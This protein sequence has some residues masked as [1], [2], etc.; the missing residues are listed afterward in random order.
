MASS[1]NNS[2]PLDSISHSL[3]LVNHLQAC[4]QA[5]AT[6]PPDLQASLSNFISGTTNTSQ[7]S[8]TSLSLNSQ[9]PTPPASQPSSGPNTPLRTSNPALPPSP[10]R[11]FIFNTTQEDAPTQIDT[12]VR[13]SQRSVCDKLYRFDNGTFLE[14]PETSKNGIAYLIRCDPDN[15]HSPQGD[16][17]YSIGPPGSMSKEGKPVTHQLVGDHEIPC[18]YKYRTC[19]G[20]KVCP[21]ADMDDVMD[22]HTKASREMVEERLARDYEHRQAGDFPTRAIFEKTVAFVQAIRRTGCSLEQH[23]DPVAHAPAKDQAFLEA[24][25]TELRRGYIPSKP[26]CPGRIVY[27]QDWRGMHAVMCEFHSD[28]CRLHYIQTIDGSYDLPYIQ[29][30]L[31]GDTEEAQRIEDAVALEYDSGPAAECTWVENCSSQRLNCPRAH[32]DKNGRLIC[33]KMKRIKCN[34]KFHIYTPLEEH[35]QDFPYTLIIVR[36]TEHNHL[37][38][39]PTK[40]PPRLRSQLLELLRTMSEELSDLTPRRLL[41]HP[42]MCAYLKQH[43]PNK[44]NATLG[45]FHPSLLN[46]SHIASFIKIVKDEVFPAGAL[47]LHRIQS[48]NFPVESQYIRHIQDFSITDLDDPEHKGSEGLRIIVCMSQEGSRRLQQVEHGQSDISFKRI[49]GKW[50]EFIVAGRDRNANASVVYCRI[51]INRQTAITH[52]RIFQTIEKIV[53]GDT[54]QPIKWRHL[55]AISN[56]EQDQQGLLLSWTGDQDGAQAKGLGMHLQAIAQTRPGY[57]LYEPHRKLSELGPYDHLHRLYR[58][59]TVHFARNIRK[60]SVTPEVRRAMSSLA[61]IEHTQWDETLLLIRTKGGRAGIDWLENKIQSQFA[62][63]AICW[64]KSKIPLY[65]WRAGD[66]HDNLVEASHANVNLEGKSCTLVGGIESGRRFDVNRMAL[67]RNFEATGVRRS[68]NSNH[69]SENATKAIKRKHAQNHENFKEPDQQIIKHNERF[70]KA[71]SR[72]NTARTKGI[73]LRN[74]ISQ[75]IDQLVVL[76]SQHEH[77][78]DPYNISKLQEQLNQKHRLIDAE[79]EKMNKQLDVFKKSGEEL[80]ELTE[81]A[82]KM[83]PGSGKY[84]PRALSTDV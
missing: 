71:E 1:S 46:H 3:D 23:Q 50:Y 81:Q 40:T 48:E 68:Y 61:C 58:V 82:G 44:P 63:E 25:H 36:G 20:L 53:H 65:V 55:Y 27:G 16:F 24:H 9:L 30:V 7:H 76:E 2:A 32:R 52:F 78:I 34:V 11:R 19:Q 64:Q 42:I 41:R 83:N 28:S 13:S 35:R 37:V 45:D 31:S 72:M 18:R 74:H 70:T 77:A 14:F 8:Q 6:I 49:N 59:C 69:L 79:K 33:P 10:T 73:E 54:G 47:H 56:D 12:C 15:W 57:D 39:L 67:L 29:A 26:H 43:F 21:H 51:Y 17:V 80:R 62:L 60:C 22:P 4:L 5:G 84:R 75:L 66:S 38:P